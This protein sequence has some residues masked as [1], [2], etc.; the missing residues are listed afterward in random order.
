MEVKEL[1]N[2]LFTKSQTLLKE[3]EQ[4]KDIFIFSNSTVDGIISGSIILKSIFNNK[5]NAALRCSNEKIEDTL[6]AII[7]EKHDF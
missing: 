2:N 1:K 7:K 5:G 3:I 4:Q 6:D